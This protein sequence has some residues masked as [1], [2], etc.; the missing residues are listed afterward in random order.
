MKKYDIRRVNEK[1]VKLLSTAYDKYKDISVI[2]RREEIN[3]DKEE[4]KETIVKVDNF[5][6]IVRS[7][8]NSNLGR[9]FQKLYKVKKFTPNEDEVIVQTL[10]SAE[11]KSAAICKLRKVPNRSYRSIQ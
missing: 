11:N 4:K 1:Y 9:G 2:E 5:P 7:K 3:S 8:S 10:Q 6:K